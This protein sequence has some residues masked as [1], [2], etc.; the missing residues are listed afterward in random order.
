M[1]IGEQRRQY[2][3]FKIIQQYRTSIK[4]KHKMLTSSDIFLDSFFC[5]H[6]FLYLYSRN[7]FDAFIEGNK[8]LKAHYNLSGIMCDPAF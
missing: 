3:Y 6:F 4:N 1:N 5:N 7:L 2:S 8:E